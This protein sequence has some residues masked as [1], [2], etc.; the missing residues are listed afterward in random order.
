MNTRKLSTARGAVRLLLAAAALL[1]LAGPARAQNGGVRLRVVAGAEQEP[2]AGA[3]VTV[4]G[5]SAVA[6]SSGVVS[7]QG[8]PPG[9][10]TMRVSRIGFVAATL[11][12]EVAEG[13]VVERTVV[14]TPEAVRVGGVAA[15]PPHGHEH[16]AEGGIRG[17]YRVT[18][19]VQGGAIHNNALWID[20]QPGAYVA[21][22]TPSQSGTPSGAP[23]VS[24]SVRMRGAR[25]TIV[26]PGPRGTMTMRVV[27]R[28]QRIS[29]DWSYNKDNLQGRIN[30]EK[31]L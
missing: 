22:W 13:A 8:V 4:E 14:L 23:L 31:T 3:Q 17:R 5:L 9:R 21:T 12:V 18:W 27:F 19:T 10:R 7:V 1:W 16:L 15:D 28:G 6:D 25:A 2:V 24:S 26:F 29:G 30:G 11:S 20:G